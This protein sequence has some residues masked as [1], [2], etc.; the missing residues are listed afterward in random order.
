MRKIIITE[1]IRIDSVDYPVGGEP[2]EVEDSVAAIASAN[3][4]ARDAESDAE[5]LAEGPALK[6]AVKPQPKKK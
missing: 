3:G 1:S 6:T 4:C 5:S 2:I